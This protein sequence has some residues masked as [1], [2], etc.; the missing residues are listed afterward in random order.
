MVRWR[1]T[2]SARMP[3]NPAETWQ[4]GVDQGKVDLIRAKGHEQKYCRLT[5]VEATLADTR[6]IVRGWCRPGKDDCFIYV[7]RPSRDFRS[8]SIEV[9]PPPRMVFLV[10]VLADGTIDDWAWRPQSGEDADLPEG[11]KGED[12]IWR[13]NPN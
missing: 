9:P 13:Q 4:V 3:Q 1:Y 10:F 8:A 6:L 2:F 12:V 7:G 11:I 5:L